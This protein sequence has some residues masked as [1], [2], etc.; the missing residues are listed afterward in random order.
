MFIIRPTEY[1]QHVG[2]ET[3]TY[4]YVHTYMTDFHFKKVGDNLRLTFSPLIYSTLNDISNG[5]SIHMFIIR[6]TEYKQHVGD[7]TDTYIYVHTYM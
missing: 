2:D 7:E 3:D 5:S 1:K 6:P 4:I